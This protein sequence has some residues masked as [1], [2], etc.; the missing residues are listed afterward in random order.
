MKNYYL[1]FS[2]LILS[3][4]L[5][6]SI[7]FKIFSDYFLG[8]ILNLKFKF[9]NFYF[10]KFKFF[11]LFFIH[12]L[13]IN[14]FFNNL[15]IENKALFI[16]FTSLIL[17]IFF[18]YINFIKNKIKNKNFLIKKVKNLIS[19]EINQI[20]GKK[21]NE[22]SNKNV[23]CFIVNENNLNEKKIYLVFKNEISFYIN[24]YFFYN[25]KQNDFIKIDKIK[26]IISIEFK[27]DNENILVLKNNSDFEKLFKIF[28]SLGITNFEPIIFSKDQVN[29]FL[30]VFTGNIHLSMNFVYYMEKKISENYLQ[31]KY[32]IKLIYSGIE[33]ILKK[34]KKIM[35]NRYLT[36]AYF[37]NGL[38]I[39]NPI[40][41]RHGYGKWKLTLQKQI[42]KYIEN[43]TVIDFG[44]N[45]C[46]L[47]I[48][49]SCEAKAKQ[50]DCV[51][52]HQDNC[53]VGENFKKIMEYQIS[54]NLTIKIHN[55]NM[56]DFIKN[57]DFKYDVAT[58]FCSLYYL[59]KQQISEVLNILS[60]KVKI[61]IIQ[62][63]QQ[64][65]IEDRAEKSNID[66]LKKVAEKNNFNVIDVYD[67]KQLVRPLFI[68]KSKK[69]E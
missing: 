18:C 19:S 27:N 58:F 28:F 68:A 34:C 11:L 48:Y 44:S 52:I 65:N 43:K 67:Q 8:K 63:N 38:G 24:A 51:E 36:T 42:Q 12:L 54:R 4:K 20:T 32:N 56:Y 53:D 9:N 59:E 17:S 5:S 37:Y 2:T 64:T 26:K 57:N 66:Y 45:C 25:L 69:N 23:Q 30:G 22:L 39:G 61:L 13:I 46:I 1:F 10:T 14:L 47:P 3:C 49:L 31:K 50:M 40:N 55:Q 16:I 21:Y 6:I 29:L 7:T 62:A 33:D 41:L 35:Q 60:K 15:I